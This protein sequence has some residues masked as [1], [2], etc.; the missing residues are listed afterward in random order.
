[1]E[2]FDVGD[3]G[4]SQRRVKKRTENVWSRPDDTARILAIPRSCCLSQTDTVFYL[5][6]LNGELYCRYVNNHG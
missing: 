5:Q 1:M 4:R 3:E 6:L 2:K